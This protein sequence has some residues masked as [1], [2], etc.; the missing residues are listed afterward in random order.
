MVRND[1]ARVAGRERASASSP[2]ALESSPPC[3]V[4]AAADAI[5][6]SAL[7]MLATNS[8]T[9]RD[10]GEPALAMSAEDR[11]VAWLPNYK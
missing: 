2:V 7:R 5:A 9:R 8:V 1:G 6:V 10:A 11:L 3:H 4:S